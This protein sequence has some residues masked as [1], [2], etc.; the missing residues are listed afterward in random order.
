MA[1]DTRDPDST[2]DPTRTHSAARLDAEANRAIYM[3]G[4]AAVG[5]V[6]LMFLIEKVF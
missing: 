2:V 1:R 5:S 3:V 6:V 4:I